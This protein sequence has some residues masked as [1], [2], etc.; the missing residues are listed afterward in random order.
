MRCRSNVTLHNFCFLL[1]KDAVQHTLAMMES[2]QHPLPHVANM[3]DSIVDDTDFP[4]TYESVALSQSVEDIAVS[5]SRGVASAIAS[6]AGPS[7]SSID[8]SAFSVVAHSSTSS[9]PQRIRLL[10]FNVEYRHYNI[11]VVLQDSNNVGK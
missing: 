4:P 5:S 2:P 7:N 3:F 9:S 1:L 6:N 11:P 10:N 8:L